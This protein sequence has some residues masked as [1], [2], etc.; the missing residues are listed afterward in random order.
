MD[1]KGLSEGGL[2]A[3]HLSVRKAA[4][5]DAANPQK[6]DPYF[7]VTEFKDWGTHR[8]EIETELSRRGIPFEPVLW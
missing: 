7:G 2:K 6:S 5:S 1:I 4:E 8:D 3:F